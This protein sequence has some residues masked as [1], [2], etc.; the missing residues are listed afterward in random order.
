[1]AELR[2]FSTTRKETADKQDQDEDG[3]GPVA[4]GRRREHVI[5]VDKKS[6][7]SNPTAKIW[8]SIGIFAMGF[9]LT[10]ALVQVQG[11]HRNGR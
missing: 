10:T 7:R 11:R 5:K 8:R 3:T 4:A 9:L 6:S 2:A 1:M